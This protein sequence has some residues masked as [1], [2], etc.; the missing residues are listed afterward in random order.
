M[1]NAFSWLHLSDLHAG[2]HAHGWLWPTLKSAFYDDLRRVHART[3][4]WDVVIFSGDLAQAGNP[5]E[6]EKVAVALSELWEVQAQL[7]FRPKLMLVPGNHDLVRPDATDPATIVLKG[8]WQQEAVR[9]RTLNDSN[10]PYR[11]LI[12]NS[13][14]NFSQWV[15]TL[16]GAGIPL[17]DAVAGMFPG[18]VST[19]LT[20]SIGPVGLVG[21]NSAWL[22]LD[23]GDSKG[24]LA[25][26]VRQLLSVTGDDPSAWCEKNAANLIITHHPTDWLHHSSQAFWHSDINPGGRFNAHL[27]GHMHEPD[28]ISTSHGGSAIRTSIQAASIFGLEKYGD[29]KLERIHGYSVAKIESGGTLRVWPRIGLRQA[30][31]ELKLVP[32]HRLNVDEDGSFTVTVNAGTSIVPSDATKTDFIIHTPSK[33][34]LDFS[35]AAARVLESLRY[36]ISAH[37]AHSKVRRVEQRRSVSALEEKR[38]VWIAA[39]WGSGSD[40]FVKSIYDSMGLENPDVYRLDLADYISRNEFL[41]GLKSKIGVGLEQLCGSLAERKDAFLIIDNAPTTAGYVE[42]GKLSLEADIELVADAILNFCPDLKVIIRSR[43]PPVHH[44][45]T[46][47]TLRSLDEADV[48]TYVLDHER[49]GPEFMRP[50]AISAIYRHTDGV[51]ARID[52]T[53]RDLEIISLDELSSNNSD[54]VR[55]DGVQDHIPQA[56]KDAVNALAG[57]SEPERARAY[58][59][60]KALAAFPQGETLERLKRFYGPQGI[61]PNHARELLEGS[62][63]ASSI[64]AGGQVSGQGAPEKLLHVPRPVR[65]FVRSITSIDDQNDITRLA[66]TLY[67]GDQWLT[68]TLKQSVATKFG[69]PAVQSYEVANANAII[70]RLLN[71][72]V[73]MDDDRQTDAALAIAKAYLVAL[74]RGD[75]YRSVVTFSRDLLARLPDGKDDVRAFLTFE[76]GRAVRM[77]GDDRDARDLLKSVDQAH[78]P[79]SMRQTLL[80]SL[81][82]AHQGIGDSGAAVDCAKELIK[83][84]K[85][86]GSALQ[87]QAIILEEDAETTPEQLRSLER[88][89]RKRGTHVVANNLALSRAGKYG[90]DA[91][92]VN[93]ALADVMNHSDAK[94]DFYNSARAIVKKVALA[95]SRNIDVSD[96]DKSLLIDAYHF[97]YSE[98]LANLFDQCHAAL[99]DLF[100]GQGEQ[101][102]L[103]RLFRHSS[104]IWRLRGDEDKEKSYLR[105]LAHTV[106]AIA[107]RD[108]K[109]VNKET[110]YYLVRAS[111]VL[112]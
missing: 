11:E 98:R 46:L 77:T 70:L 86:S 90:A 6:Y 14:A 47:V 89:C 44:A 32:D 110:A 65:D 24:S 93:A 104:L 4:P 55:I 75:H 7:G 68:G 50:D 96:D 105:K 34:G 39:E 85:N 62:L 59:L 80:S 94:T 12:A 19:V 87:A 53:L 48:R 81:A 18:D 106:H 45:Q 95:N 60:L 57:S 1:T 97:L 33:S 22:Q 66:A 101:E 20:T 28:V 84:G 30:N 16:Q 38:T 67:F 112:S 15:Q 25:V 64:P 71:D 56:L 99:W 73:E 78:L 91:E 82:L 74:F 52:I 42:P 51:T 37:G 76:L 49:G 13:F 102:N 31:G 41:D 10:S 21:L 88:L 43:R 17:V 92:E 9:N 109:M 63:I 72:A 26:D 3:G 83:I 103:L 69:N 23:G 36:F 61:F 79:L 29:L 40:G 108:F 100:S 35:A 2:M 58:D 54:L 8:W 107:T 5:V 27:F 111:A